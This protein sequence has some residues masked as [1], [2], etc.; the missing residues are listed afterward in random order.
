[1]PTP[2]LFRLACLA[3]LASFVLTA[4]G[5]A[6][7]TSTSAPDSTLR[8]AQG[9]APG[10][11]TGTPADTSTSTPTPAPQ[12]EVAPEAL[13]GIHIQV[14]HAF[15]GAAADVFTNQLAQF[16][17]L[18]QW[19]IV[20]YQTAYGDY[21][22]LFEDVDSA[23]TSTRR[24]DLVVALPEQTFTWE[25]KG[26]VVDLNPYLYD[27]A[28]GLTANEI[29]DIPATFWT[30]DPVNGQRLG[31]PAQRSARFLFYNQTWA[32]ELGF[33]A[34]PATAD[35]FRQQACAANAYYRQDANKQNDGYGGWIVNTQP[36]TMLSW[37][38]AFG[39][40]VV[41]VGQS[42]TIKD[43][44]IHFATPAN[45]SALEFLKGLYDEHCAW[46][47]TEPNPYES[48]ARRSALFVTGDLAEAPRLTQ[49]LAR[50]NNSDEW[51]LLPFPGL[52]GAVLVTS[53]PSYT[54][55]QST[56]E[57][58]FAAQHSLA[59]WLFVRWLL[60][61]EN[62]AKWVEATG[63]L[64]L[65]FSALDSLGEYRA[66]HPQWNNAVGY[67]PEAQASPQLA[68]WRMAQYVLADGA[69]F[70]FRTN[71]AVEKI[72]SVLDEMDATVEEIS[73]K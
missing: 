9:G 61:A 48:F 13:R 12:I 29:A 52:N 59:A 50:L 63:L 38:L 18:N 5:P 11:L 47:S 10:L 6:A 25:A 49:T 34:P 62:Q 32:R 26:A 4:C 1:M 31:A 43:G 15:S 33:S 40:G 66:G 70:I 72:P 57:K 54:L 36:D 64:P 20:V 17:T 51:T 45:Q 46:I 53:G 68:A 44:E 24:P 41:M 65:R 28:W 37:L 2:R 42:P 16:N 35:E 58:Q 71:L 19:G 14:W 7:S 30:Q 39:G 56:P 21:S 67:I 73:N 69:G 22:S 3:L 55:L 60:S 8:P 27:P 23:L